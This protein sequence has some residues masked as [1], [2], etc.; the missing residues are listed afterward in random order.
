MVLSI[1]VKTYSPFFRSLREW[2][3]CVAAIG[4]AFFVRKLCLRTF[5]FWGQLWKIAFSAKISDI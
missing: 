3:S 2:Q 1:L 4:D 5:L